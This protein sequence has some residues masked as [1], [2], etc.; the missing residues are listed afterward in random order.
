RTGRPT[1]D[2]L[3]GLSRARQRGLIEEVRGRIRPT[4]R[5]LDFL[6]DLQSIFLH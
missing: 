4:P 6:N 2:L 5:G 1:E 3:E